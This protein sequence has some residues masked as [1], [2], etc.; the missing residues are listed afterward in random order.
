MAE[1][2]SE[3]MAPRFE[4]GIMTT[5]VS[6]A[7]ARAPSDGAGDPEAAVLPVTTAKLEEPHLLPSGIPAQVG[8]PVAELTPGTISHGIPLESA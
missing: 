7:L 4:S 1:D 3:A 2:A 6:A 8:A 5:S